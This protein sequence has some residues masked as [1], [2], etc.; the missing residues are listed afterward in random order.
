MR[1]TWNL[2][3][4]YKNT[5]DP[6]I[7]KDLKTFEREYKKFVKKY[8]DK[9]DY[10]TKE[11]SLLMALKD[12]ETLQERATSKPLYYFYYISALN[13]SD[14]KAEAMINKLSDRLTKIVNEALF[15]T[16]NLSKIKE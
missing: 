12:Y 16:I 11:S 2:K 7:E 8:K 6:Q 10:M 5:K 4:F 3:L 15:F 9:S 14:Q 13:S 1:T